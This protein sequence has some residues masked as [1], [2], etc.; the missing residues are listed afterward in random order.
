MKID[1]LD[2]D[3]LSFYSE[4]PDCNWVVIFLG[5][6]INEVTKHHSN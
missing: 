4:I 6:K 5:L 3:L 1:Y 2:K